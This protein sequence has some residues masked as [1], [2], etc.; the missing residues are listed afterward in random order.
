MRSCATDSEEWPI[1][2]RKEARTE[3]LPVGKARA[4]FTLNWVLQD[5]ISIG[6]AGQW[7]EASEMMK[8]DSEARTP[9]TSID[10]VAVF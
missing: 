1:R 10:R 3:L 9:A 7:P 5:Q 6:V 4:D 8:G 2:A